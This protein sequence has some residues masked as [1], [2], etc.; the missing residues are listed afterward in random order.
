MKSALSQ[1]QNTVSQV[2]EKDG[3]NIRIT[4]RIASS[5][6]VFTRLGSQRLLPIRRSKKMFAENRFGLNEE[7]ITETKACFE[8]KDKMFYKNAADILKNPQNYCN[9]LEGNLLMSKVEFCL[10]LVVPLFILRKYHQLNNILKIFFVR[11]DIF[12]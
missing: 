10:K 3:K 4:S 7:M 1:R 6:T 11:E 9:T 8:S 2:D 12:I 5:S